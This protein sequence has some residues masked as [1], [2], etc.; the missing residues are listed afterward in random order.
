LTVAQ[1]TGTIAA[2]CSARR[3]WCAA[4]VLCVTGAAGARQA[5]EPDPKAAGAQLEAVIDAGHAWLLRHQDE[6]GRWSASMFALHDPKRAPSTGVGKPDQDVFVTALVV[7]A[8]YGIGQRPDAAGTHA[9]VCRGLAWLQAQV[10]AD[11]SIGVTGSTTIVRDTVFGAWILA[12]AHGYHARGS[13]GADLTSTTTRI[14][15]WRKPD[16]LWPQHPD[17]PTCDWL[18]SFA[19]LAFLSEGRA[20]PPAVATLDQIAALQPIQGSQPAAGA[21]YLSAWVQRDA[22]KRASLCDLLVAEPPAAGRPATTV[23]YLGWYC[24]TQ[25][26]QFHDAAKWSLWQQALVKAGIAMQR[27]DGSFAGSWDPNDVRG[28][29]GGRVYATAAMLLNLEVVWRKLYRGK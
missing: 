18:T 16:N 19:A 15:A 26:M 20:E 2:M 21:A 29:E 28:R 24:A 10:Q 4:A 23:D 5:Q 8:C 6:D 3:L 14:G 1:G 12:S 22:G 13:A 9:H 7:K 27:Q 11:G 17:A 25:A